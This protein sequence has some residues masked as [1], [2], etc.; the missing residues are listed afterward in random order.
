MEKLMK[1]KG[2][3]H[4]GVIICINCEKEIEVFDSEQVV[5]KYGICSECR[6]KEDIIE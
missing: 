3:Q 4:L 6:G 2:Q 1:A 5:T